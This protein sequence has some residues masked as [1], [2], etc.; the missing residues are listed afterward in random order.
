M[1]AYK[2]SEPFIQTTFDLITECIRNEVLTN[3]LE[4]QVEYQPKRDT[5]EQILSLKLIIEKSLDYN[6]PVQVLFF[7]YLKAFNSVCQNEVWNALEKR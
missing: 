4:T 2:P 6:K 7:D 3:V 1:Y 5:L